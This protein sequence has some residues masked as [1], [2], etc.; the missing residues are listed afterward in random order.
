MYMNGTKKNTFDKILIQA[1][2]DKKTNL[3]VLFKKRNYRFIN[4]LY[5][6]V[7][8]HLTLFDLNKIL[9]Y[10]VHLIED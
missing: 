10:L 7:K 4:V 3:I 2:I 1:G 5:I 8:I 9:V 6:D